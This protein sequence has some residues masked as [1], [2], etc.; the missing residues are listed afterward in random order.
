ME[1]TIVDRC[2]VRGVRMTEQRRIIA[3]VLEQAHDHPHIDDV[4]KRAQ[5]YDSRISLATVYRTVRLFQDKGIL[6]KYEF[7]GDR[8]RYETT[9]RAHHDHLIDIETGQVIEFTDRSIE[10]LQE[11]IATRLGYRLQGHKL[12]LYG[13]KIASPNNKQTK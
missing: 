12:E 3:K 1:E 5:R 2:L 8:A 6:E 9:A 4:H 13:V 10:A 7:S 11:Q